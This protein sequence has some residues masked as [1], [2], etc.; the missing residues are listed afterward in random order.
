[1]KPKTI[2]FLAA[3]FMVGACD[4]QEESVFCTLEARP[5]LE[6]QI[7]DATTGAPAVDGAL[8]L[9]VDG[10]YSETLEGPPAG[11]MSEPPSLFGAYERAGTYDITI[12]KTGFKP[13]LAR[14][15]EVEAD[16]CHVITVEVDARLEREAQ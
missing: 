1:M 8:V 7:R 12:G 16:E 5:G 6:I 2:A 11:E 14:G 4:T 13:W 3:L 9:L 15:I 10:D